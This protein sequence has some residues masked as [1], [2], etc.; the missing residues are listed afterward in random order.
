MDVD[1]AV[2]LS[3]NREGI[4]ISRIKALQEDLVDAVVVAV[5]NFRG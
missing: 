4:F 5:D 2:D 1:V 3:K